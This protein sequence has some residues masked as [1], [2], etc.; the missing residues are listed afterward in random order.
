MRVFLF[1]FLLLLHMQ[2]TQCMTLASVIPDVLALAPAIALRC[3]NNTVTH[4]MPTLLSLP[5]PSLQTS[6]IFISFSCQCIGLGL[7]Y[8]I[9]DY[10]YPG[11]KLNS[12]TDKKIPLITLVM[13]WRILCKFLEITTLLGIHAC[14]LC[15]NG[16]LTT[17][18]NL[19]GTGMYLC[20]TQFLSFCLLPISKGIVERKNFELDKK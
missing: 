3:A 9:R 8:L 14:A 18:K 11:K 19:L 1:T 6:G 20:T 13:K 12:L 2:H 17:K 15:L 4:N 5:S 10:L 7:E 16:N